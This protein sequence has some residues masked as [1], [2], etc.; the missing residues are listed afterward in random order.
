MTPRTRNLV[1]LLLALPGLAAP[2]ISFIEVGEPPDA[3]Q[4]AFVNF[5]ELPGRAQPQPEVAYSTCELAVGYEDEPPC[6]GER[7]RVL[8]DSIPWQRVYYILITLPIFLPFLILYRQIRSLNP[9]RSMSNRAGRW[10]VTVAI[11][12]L[13]YFAATSLWQLPGQLLVQWSL[14]DFSLSLRPL[15]EQLLRMTGLFGSI[16]VGAWLL[17]RLWRRSNRPAVPDSTECAFLIV[18][19][20]AVVPELVT[21]GLGAVS[22][23]STDRLL[24]GYPLLL[25]TCVVYA[26]TLVARFRE[27]RLGRV[28]TDPDRPPG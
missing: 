15:A 18:Y 5:L 12:W 23:G 9:Q 8:W 22:P 1:L 25:W 6:V 13:A 3:M 26:V 10:A 19:L 14:S 24:L 21:S 17:A 20:V 4:W 2:W 16:A 7:V 28:E 27:Q 11:A